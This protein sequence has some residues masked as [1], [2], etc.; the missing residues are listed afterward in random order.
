MVRAG[1]SGGCAR[2]SARPPSPAALLH[3]RG[4]LGRRFTMCVR[5]A[6]LTARTTIVPT[7]MPSATAGMATS[8]VPRFCDP[9]SGFSPTSSVMP[10]SPIVPGTSSQSEGYRHP[11]NTRDPQNEG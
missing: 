11:S 5:I 10:I 1:V 8:A 3:G 2:S 9:A 7:R 4:T 6:I